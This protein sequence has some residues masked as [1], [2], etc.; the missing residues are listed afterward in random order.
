MPKAFDANHWDYYVRDVFDAFYP[1]IG[2][3]TRR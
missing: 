1:G 2:T 3:C